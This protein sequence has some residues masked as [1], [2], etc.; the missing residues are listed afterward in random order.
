MLLWKGY[1]LIQMTLSNVLL[2]PIT[3]MLLPDHKSTGFTLIELLIVISIISILT[4]VGIANLKDFAQAQVITR[5]TGQIQS[6]LRL[7]HT[8]A[9]SSVKCT[10]TEAAASWLVTFQTDKSTLTLICKSLTLET[11]V[12]DLTLDS[13]IEI[14][15]VTT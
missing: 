6:F 12:K 8:N 13:N 7:A 2:I 9:S 14:N 11:V 4:I 10:D 15:Q 1:L 5:A 3:I